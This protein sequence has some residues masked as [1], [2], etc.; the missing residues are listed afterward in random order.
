MALVVP[1]MIEG[2]IMHFVQ[3]GSESGFVD[4]LDLVWR[5]FD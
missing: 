4:R 3:S 2:N 5:A 1:W